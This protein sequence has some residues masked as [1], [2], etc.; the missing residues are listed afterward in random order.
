MKI[1]I[2]ECLKPIKKRKRKTNEYFLMRLS[3]K[4]IDGHICCG[5]RERIVHSFKLLSGFYLAPQ[6][7]LLREAEHKVYY[8]IVLIFGFVILVKFLLVDVHIAFWTFQS[9]YTCTLQV[10]FIGICDLQ[11]LDSRRFHYLMPHAIP[12]H[13]RPLRSPAKKKGVDRSTW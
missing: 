1:L 7:W 3:Y 10:Y 8:V 12:V 4:Y 6:T 13:K 9:S 11:Y 2:K 5:R